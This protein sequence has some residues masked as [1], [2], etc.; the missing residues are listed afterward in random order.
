MNYAPI[1]T[2]EIALKRVIF[3]VFFILATTSIFSQESQL[4]FGLVKRE[5]MMLTADF[6]KS[7]PVYSSLPLI[8]D[9]VGINEDG[10]YNGLLLSKDLYGNYVFVIVK[11]NS[12]GIINVSNMLRDGATQIVNEYLNAIAFYKIV[13]SN[14]DI[15]LETKVLFINMMNSSK[16]K[17]ESFSI[18]GSTFFDSYKLINDL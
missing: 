6:S 10:T 11:F 5:S 8:E 18:I 17:G 7:P 14:E 1:I 16:E 4:L 12:D 13:V 15:N 3:V 2:K 9:T